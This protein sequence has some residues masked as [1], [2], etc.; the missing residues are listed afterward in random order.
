MKSRQ[1]FI[2]KYRDASPMVASF[3]FCLSF[4]GTLFIDLEPKEKPVPVVI[5]QETTPYDNDWRE[6]YDNICEPEET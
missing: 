2:E 5:P 3:V 6:C 1:G 4:C